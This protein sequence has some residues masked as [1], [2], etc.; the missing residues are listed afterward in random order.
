M[1]SEHKIEI[2]LSLI[3]F[4]I[5]LFIL[6]MVNFNKTESNSKISYFFFSTTDNQLKFPA[7]TQSRR[8]QLI[9][10]NQNQDNPFANNVFNNHS[11]FSN[12]QATP[13]KTNKSNPNVPQYM[14]YAQK[15]ELS[16]SINSSNQGVFLSRRSA[17]N[18]GTRQTGNTNFSLT[19]LINVETDYN[20]P[21]FANNAEEDLILVDPMTDPE[22]T[23][24]IPVGGSP[25]IMIGFIVIYLLVKKY[26]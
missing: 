20:R 3:G 11:G 25:L 2:I 5:L 8:N 21:L 9:A 18:T 15:D 6:S 4:S 1:N 12:S 7:F 26:H 23:E 10:K 24:R 14:A 16:V 22:D 13:I 17:N 19:G